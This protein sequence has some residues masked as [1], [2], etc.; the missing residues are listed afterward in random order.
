MDR[1]GGSSCVCRAKQEE[2]GCFHVRE[3]GGQPSGTLVGEGER[4]FG[5]MR[6]GSNPK[7][8][9]KTSKYIFQT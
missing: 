6:F 9:L 4:M 8:I 3:G 5:R 1:D 2:R 7:R